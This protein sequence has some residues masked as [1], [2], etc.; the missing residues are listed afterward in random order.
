MGF[1]LGRRSAGSD[2]RVF[3]VARAVAYGVSLTVCAVTPARAQ[4]PQESSPPPSPTPVDSSSAPSDSPPAEGTGRS[5]EPAAGAA[6]APAIVPPANQAAP[7]APEPALDPNAS[8]PRRG[9]SSATSTHGSTPASKDV[10]RGDES[11]DRRVALPSLQTNSVIIA[12]ERLFGVYA[13]QAS[14]TFAPGAQASNSELH[15][16]MVN[17]LVGNTST[18]SPDGVLNPLATPRIGTDVIL[19]FGFTAGA[20]LGYLSVAGSRED[21]QP[22]SA[23]A[24]T[25]F[26]DGHAFFVSPRVGWIHSLT[27]WL[28]IWPRGGMTYVTLGDSQG[29][30]HTNV[31]YLTVTLDPSVVFVPFSH[32]AV[33]IGPIFD[34]GVGGGGETVAN[35]SAQDLD[36]SF[37]NLGAS[38]G[39]AV[40][41]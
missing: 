41:F 19:P 8:G 16:T 20:S 40:V 27:N 2:D 4:A 9:T 1:S 7:P 17:V 31:H 6:T 21:R 33:V 12:A 26:P 5:A 24:T 28:G 13:W 37:S 35:G 29:A 25:P 10:V 18:N 32:V 34:I 11:S 15:G 23:P 36:A 39:S 38:V 3:V 14:M 30:D 22:G